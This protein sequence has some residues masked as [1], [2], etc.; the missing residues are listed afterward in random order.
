MNKFVFVAASMMGVAMHGH[1]NEDIAQQAN[2]NEL[3]D[4][5]TV[6]QAQ[7]R[8]DWLA[9]CYDGLLVEVWEQM[10]NTTEIVPK[11]QKLNQ[12]KALWLTPDKAQYLT[13]AN[14]DFTN[15]YG[16][17]AGNS[18]AQ[19]CSTMPPEYVPVALQ[20]T[21]LTHEY[22][23]NK[24]FDNEWEWIEK[25]TVE[26][27]VHESLS[28]DYTAVSGKVITLP[29]GRTVKMSV[30]PGNK[31]PQYPSYVAL[32]VWI[33]WNQDGQLAANEIVY[34]SASDAPFQ[35]TFD[36]PTDAADGV[37][38]MRVASDAGGGSDDACKRTL[39]GEVEDYLVTIR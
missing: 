20:T 14:S 33:D 16:W 13:F 8:F 32:R 29:A 3:G 25:V 36:V 18:D 4:L 11:E 10:Y 5:L 17:Q 19:A 1:A 24:S 23:A 2:Y 39:Y 21:Q 26:D 22:C 7:G 35:F 15:P 37:T 6:S 30:T 34:K 28:H 12:L 38:L 27:F 9:K 31:D